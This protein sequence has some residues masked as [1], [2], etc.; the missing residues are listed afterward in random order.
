MSENEKLEDLTTKLENY[1]KTNCE[2]LKLQAVSHSSVI[3]SSLISGFLIAMTC[4]LLSL[5]I[6]LGVVFYLS[7]I[8]GNNY[9]GFGVVAGFLL[10]VVLVLVL[11]RVSLIEKPLRNKIIENILRNTQS[12][13]III[14][15]PSKLNNPD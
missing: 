7:T 2:I 5:F 14:E 9:A 10:I 3:G 13:D 15:T 6:G 1:V 12:Q 8:F 4:F 11:A